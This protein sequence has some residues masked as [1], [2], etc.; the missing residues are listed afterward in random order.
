METLTWKSAEAL[1]ATA[2][3]DGLTSHVAPTGAPV[4]VKDT[5]PEKPSID[6]MSSS[7]VAVWPAVIVADV[8]PSD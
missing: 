6:W 7:Y 2:R 4:H 8:A 1:A 5:G 3:G